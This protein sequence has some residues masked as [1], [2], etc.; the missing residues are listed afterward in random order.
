MFHV[1]HLFFVKYKEKYF[2]GIN[3]SRGTKYIFFKS[4]NKKYLKEV[5]FLIKMFFIREES[6]IP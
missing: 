3:V 1:E 2:E 6:F 4:Q 5:I